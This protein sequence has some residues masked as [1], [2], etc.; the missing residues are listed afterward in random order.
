M[1][2]KWLIGQEDSPEKVNP[3]Q[4]A[5]QSSAPETTVEGVYKGKTASQWRDKAKGSDRAAQE[6][7]ERS[8]TD[9]FMSQWALGVAAREY[10]LCA[11]L[12]ERDGMWEFE[13]LF[14]PTGALVD[15]A[16]YV[17]TK[18]GKWVWRIGSGQAVTWFDNS[19]AK[20]G[21]LR[22]KRDMAKGFLIGAIRA[23]GIVRT[24]G[25]GHAYVERDPRSP[26]EIV[27]D[28]RGPNSYPDW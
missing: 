3:P 17:K 20:D 4:Q 18:L 15:N 8:D 22:R 11:K 21:S 19:Q 10:E 24:G 27:D 9:G 28:G 12:A 16:N 26:I 25:K 2:P 14:T 13:A 1:E 6:S 5:E 7:Y 23:R